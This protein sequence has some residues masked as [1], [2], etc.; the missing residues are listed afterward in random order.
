MKDL[1]GVHRALHDKLKT[2]GGGGGTEAMDN[3]FWADLQDLLGGRANVQPP[4]GTV[5]GS[6]QSDEEEEGNSI[7][8]L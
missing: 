7:C 5:G 8:L 4:A 2:S 3:P 6:M 1:K